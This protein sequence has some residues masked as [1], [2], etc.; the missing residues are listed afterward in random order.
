MKYD[1]KVSYKF[2]TE[3]EGGRKTLPFQG[4]RCDFWYENHNNDQIFMIW[5][6][7]ENSDGTLFEPYMP[8]PETG[9]ARMIIINPQMKD[10]HKGKILIGTKG[11]FTEGVR[12]IA[13]CEV[14]EVLL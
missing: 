9:T 8:V 5:P 14:I 10:Y 7:F 11:N 2:L 1:F 4:I 3:E 13:E 6:E 12:K